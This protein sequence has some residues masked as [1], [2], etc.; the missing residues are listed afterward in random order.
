MQRRY[1]IFL[2]EDNEGKNNYSAYPREQHLNT[3]AGAELLILLDL[4]V[5][6]VE[7]SSVNRGYVLNTFN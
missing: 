7:N 1:Q 3:V 4:V 2:D 5:M 6:L